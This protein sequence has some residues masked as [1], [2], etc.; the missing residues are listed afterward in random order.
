MELLTYVLLLYLILKLVLFHSLIV[1][2]YIDIIFVGLPPPTN[3]RATVLTPRSVEV[4]WTLSSS[5]DVT[6]YTV[7]YTTTA[8]YI[9]ISSRS[10]SVM[11]SG[12]SAT[13]HTLNNLEENTLY[14]IGVRATTS[15]N[16]MS[17][18]IEIPV[19]TYTDGK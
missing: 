19:R 17:S 3:V 4:T 6:G 7:S 2:V 15:D 9:D 5:P 8:E 1:Y 16:R 10:G 11:V 18:N 13:S 12:N 14:T